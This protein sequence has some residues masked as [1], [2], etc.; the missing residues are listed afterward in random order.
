MKK[1]GEM[2]DYFECEKCGNLEFRPVYSFSL[3]FH[4]VN[5]SDNLIYERVNEERFECTRCNARY[6]K[7]EIRQR[8][9]ELKRKRRI[10]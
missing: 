10:D 6:T 3:R 7:D 5:F 8:L 9:R 1:T 4:T 2:V